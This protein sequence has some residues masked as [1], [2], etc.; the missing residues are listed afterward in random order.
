MLYAIVLFK[1][2]ELWHFNKLF[3]LLTKMIIE[4]KITFQSKKNCVCA[5]KSF[6]DS[7]LD[8]MDGEASPIVK[9]DVVCN[10]LGH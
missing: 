3:L 7:F 4:V 1:P 8:I 10:H 2:P 5:F 6:K 9:Q